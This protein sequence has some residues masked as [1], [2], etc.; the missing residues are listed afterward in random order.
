VEEWMKSGLVD[1]RRMWTAAK[2]VFGSII[3]EYTLAVMLAAARR[4]PEIIGH[5]RWQPIEP[6]SLY[7]MTVGVVGAGGIGSAVLELL[8]P[9]N[10]HGIALTRSGRPVPGAAECLDPA[11]LDRLL[12]RSD[13]VV[14]AAPETS[15]TIGLLSA[16]R[17]ALLKPHS[18]LIN[19][20]RGSIVDTNALVE[21]LT[22]GHI[23]GAALDVTNPE[24]LPADHPLWA[25]PNVI[26]S[27]HTAVT[28]GLGRAA[29]SERVRINVARFCAGKP[30]IGVVDTRLMY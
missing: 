23:G 21:A 10:V 20:G 3:A 5:R 26:I 19:V 29:F 14:L 28:A 7:G 8:R 13:Y 4:L 27:S 9:F 12:E 24:P 15:E 1:E 6:G 25:L 30:L 17:L 18:W 11:G 22:N 16:D 2:G